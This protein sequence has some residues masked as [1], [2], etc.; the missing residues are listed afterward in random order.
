MGPVRGCEQSFPSAHPTDLTHLNR[1]ALH[2]D[3]TKQRPLIVAR[4]ERCLYQGIG[5][6]TN[7]CIVSHA[8]NGSA[9]VRIVSEFPTEVEKYPSMARAQ[10]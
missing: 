4:V 10:D 7:V 2:Y 8:K 9:T 6:L 5:I 1:I 3:F